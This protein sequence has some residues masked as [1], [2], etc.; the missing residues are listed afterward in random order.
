MVEN[1]IPDNAAHLEALLA[2]HGVH[3]H[4]PMDANKVLAIQDRVFVLAC[5]IDDL[6]GEVGVLVADHFGEGVFDGRVVGVDE[7]A[8]DIL[9]CE[10]RL[11]WEVFK[12]VWELADMVVWKA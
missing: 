7:V 8:V 9:D 1:L 4:V 6:D 12:S 5:G 10:R 11:A 3:N 2:R